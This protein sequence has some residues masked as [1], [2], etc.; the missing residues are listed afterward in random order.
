[1]GGMGEV[2]RAHDTR[3]ARDVALKVI[4]GDARAFGDIR[5]RFAREA[6]AIASLNHPNVTTLYDV[7]PDYLVMEL[8][9][10]PTLAQNIANGPLTLDEAAGLMLQMDIGSLLVVDA[11]GHLIGILTD[12]DFGV[13]AALGA[14][15]QPAG[16]QVLGHRLQDE[17][18]A[19]QIYRAAASRRVRDVMSTPVVTVDENASIDT[20][21]ARM[22]QN[23]I[24]H[25]PVVRGP[26]P[27]G[28]VSSRDLLHL[29]FAQPPGS[30][31]RPHKDD[32]E[33]R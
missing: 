16:P 32:S 11:R 13:G 26:I 2:Y 18:P 7:G 29:V 8:V 17:I 9:E 25:L 28:V 6:H 30:E 22:F 23:H 4:R 31:R 3:L 5:E 1:M 24:R 21:L 19:S 20:V 14:G 12:T 33:A 15:G 10:G 27:V